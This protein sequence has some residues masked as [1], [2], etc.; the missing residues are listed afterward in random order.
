MEV[1]SPTFIAP[2]DALLMG[3]ATFRVPTFLISEIYLRRYGLK[4]EPFVDLFKWLI[5]KEQ[6]RTVL[7]VTKEPFID[8]IQMTNCQGTHQYA[9]KSSEFL[10]G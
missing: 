7:S 2:F 9:M 10:D 8:F 3:E 6:T 4:S 5:V 1:L